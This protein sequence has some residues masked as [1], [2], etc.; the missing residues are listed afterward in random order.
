MP[1]VQVTMLEGRTI[2]QKRRAVKRIT[3]VLREELDVKPEGLS[4]VFVEV[5]RHSYARN[6]ILISDR[7]AKP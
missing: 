2:E 3:E 7:D 1:H 4:I 6:G 5:P